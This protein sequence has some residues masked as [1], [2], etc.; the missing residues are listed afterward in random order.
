M[1]E[2]FV[3]RPM[4]EISGRTLFA[5]D[6]RIE[7]TGQFSLIGVLAGGV[8]FDAFPASFP[9][10]ALVVEYQQLD[11]M[12]ARE[13]RLAAFMPGVEPDAAFWEQTHEAEAWEKFGPP[14]TDPGQGPYP[15][16]PVRRVTQVITLANVDVP[17]PGVLQV[18]AFRDGEVI[19]L[20]GLEIRHAPTE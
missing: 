2:A 5:E 19:S 14:P 12:P 7:V 8:A 18:R 4:S 20:G 13:V 15:F 11:H 1:V 10:L 17:R 3:S 16:P 9:K 6:A